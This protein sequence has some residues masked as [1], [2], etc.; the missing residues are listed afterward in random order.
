[1]QPPFRFILL[2]FGCAALAA[3]G[4]GRASAQDADP[5]FASDFEIQSPAFYVS[6]RTGSDSNAGTQAKPW[7]TINRA[8][9]ASNGAPAGATVYVEAGNY[10]S[11]NVVFKRDGIRL[12]GY[13]QSP[14]DQP[15]ILANASIN[16]G[17]GTPSFPSFN[18]AD[19]PLL[20]GSSRAVGTAMDLKGRKNITIRN[21]NIRKF[22]IGIEAGKYGDQEFLEAH[23]L[24]NVNV[25]T[26]GDTSQGYA[27]YAMKF[28]GIS[29]EFSN[30]NVVRNALIINAAA[31]GLKFN[32][33]DNLADNVRV[34]GTEANG[35]A[36]TDYYITVIGSYN[37]IRNSYIWRKPG[38]DHSGHGYTIKDNRDQQGGGPAIESSHNLFENNV[39]VYMGEGYTVRHRGVK[40]N[41]FRNNIAYGPFDGQAES[42]S[43]GNGITIRDGANN[44]Q[45]ID[46]QMINT[47]DAIAFSDS[48]EDE[49][50]PKPPTMGS[51]NRIIGATI[52]QSYWGIVF[53]RGG[54][55]DDVGDNTIEDSEFTLIRFMFYAGEPA[56]LM[57]Y[58]NSTFGGTKG[59]GNANGF[60]LEAARGGGSSNISTITR[61]Q[62]PGSSFHNFNLPSGW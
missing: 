48:D 16:P 42:C 22:D 38:S 5:I 3:A 9:N 55:I 15:P 29:T 24:N 4:I 27:G 44:N 17:N 25:S 31:E 6:V 11:E 61:S 19:M 59:T 33:N 45:F 2:T 18:P 8:V 47:C 54:D 39:S 7:K 58:S 21:F 41:I 56:S 36:S 30:G 53:Q 1:M 28:G 52:N 10:G 34:Y 50:A 40:D 43:G 32:G 57:R 51:N 23:V 60:F 26:I 13:K 49:G 35:A 37:E 14:G 12:I 62:F 46:M 20:D